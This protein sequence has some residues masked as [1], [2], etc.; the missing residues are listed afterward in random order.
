[1]RKL[2]YV[3]MMSL[4]GFIEAEPNAPRIGLG[5]A[6]NSSGTFLKGGAQAYASPKGSV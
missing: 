2:I 5:R 1:M 6:N 3:Q 4:D